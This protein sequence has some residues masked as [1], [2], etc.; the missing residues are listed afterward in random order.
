MNTRFYTC[1]TNTGPWIK[2]SGHDQR[3][4]CGFVLL[5]YT[6]AKKTR[7]MPA[8]PSPATPSL[9]LA[10]DKLYT[11]QRQR[12][13]GSSLARSLALK[14]QPNPTNTTQLHATHIHTKFL[15]R[16]QAA[17]VGRANRNTS[18]DSLEKHTTVRTHTHTPPRLLLTRNLLRNP[19][20]TQN[21]KRRRR[22][23]GGG[24]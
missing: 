12:V 6:Y 5:T 10:L 24:A 20:L 4:V 3:E 1:A 14:P 2:Q 13:G 15:L 8:S 16:A 11:H 22:R 19:L 7:A 23:S 17:P 18:S 21:A 9:G